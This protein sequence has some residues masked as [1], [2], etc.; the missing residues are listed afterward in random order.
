MTSRCWASRG[1]PCAPSWRARYPVASEVPVPNECRIGLI[2]G[3]PLCLFCGESKRV[4]L[5]EIWSSHEFMLEACCEGLHET[6]VREM[7]DDPAWARALLKHLG[8][9]DFT[10]HR[11]RRLADDGC[12]GMLLDWQL[13][14]RDIGFGLAGR[15]I[16]RHHA[17]CAAPVTWRFGQACWNGATMIGV[18]S[19]GNPVARALCHQGALEVN[20]LCIRRDIPRALAWNAASMLYGWSAREAERRGC[21]RIVTYTRA[22]EDGGSLVA[23]GWTP[24]A[25]VRGRG[26]HSGRRARATAMPSLT[27]PVGERPCI[28]A[29]ASCRAPGRNA[30]RRPTIAW[31]IR[32]PTTPDCRSTICSRRPERRWP[33]PS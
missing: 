10:G 19:V 29:S 32:G 22:D 3:S 7:A 27:R 24:E 5:F 25:T 14:L 12:C 6:V 21:S 13:E 26:W 20:R 33:R 28:R 30:G 23:A 31:S 4:E 1:W 2:P 15:F 18:V 8:I 9:E 16:N 11:L 17:H